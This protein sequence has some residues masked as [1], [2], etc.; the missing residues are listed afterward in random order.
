MSKHALEGLIDSLESLIVRLQWKPKGTEWAN[1]Y[2]DTNYSD[3]GLKHKKEIVA[4]FLE[5]VSPNHAWDL[6]ANLGMFS[7]I[8]ASKGIETISFDVDPAAVEKNYIDCIAKDEKRV[9]PLLI[10]LTNPSPAIG[11]ENRER[12]SLQERGP[13]EIVLALAFVHHLAISNNI[14]L[15]MMASFFCRI[16]TW[17]IIEFIPKSDSQV[18]RLLRSREDIFSSYTQEAFEVEFSKLFRI[19]KSIRI[20]ESERTLYLMEKHGK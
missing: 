12:M 3:E 14:P 20:K 15:K 19:R 9:L 7:R 13:V 8:A 6:G 16:C 2:D 4:G 10:D 11:W 17:L 18:Q 1:Y 5:K